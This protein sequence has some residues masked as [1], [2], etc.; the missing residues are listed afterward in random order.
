MINTKNKE[1]KIVGAGPSGLA[2]GISLAKAGYKVRIF[3]KNNVVGKRFHGDF[4][5]IENW[6]YEQDA[7]EHIQG[8]NI[9]LGFPCYSVRE[10]KIIGPKEKIYTFKFKSNLLYL[11]RRGVEKDTLDYN[12]YQQ[13]KEAGVDIIFN[14][15]KDHRE[16]GDI[17]SQGYF[18]DKVTDAIVLGY[19]FLTNNMPS[20]CWL[21]VDD[22]VAPDGYG[23][24]FAANGRATLGVCIFRDYGRGKEYLNKAWQIFQRHIGFE[25]EGRKS[26]GGTSN[27][28]FMKKAVFSGRLYVGEAAGFI[29]AMWGFGIKYAL[30]SGHLAA[31]S[32]IRNQ[33]YEKLWKKYIYPH[34]KASLVIRC[35]Y[36]MLG[37]KSYKFALERMKKSKEPLGLMRAVND[38]SLLHKIGMPL[39]FFLL[40]SKYKDRRKF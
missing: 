10:L 9:G 27:T 6:V 33:S 20:Q 22:A 14:S 19:N 29:D 37:N 17:V 32:I 35:Y 36:K 13:A 25:A 26:F 30:I 16:F 11:L 12:L 34:I 40:R 23:Y 28:F 1:V 15:S 31:Q 7:L 4:Q 5:G 24:F 2:A 18:P 21:I 8:M 39:A 38:Y 3:E